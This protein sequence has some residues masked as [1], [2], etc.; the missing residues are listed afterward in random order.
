[1]SNF[2]V[3]Y[4]VGN[5]FGRD[6]QMWPTLLRSEFLTLLGGDTVDTRRIADVERPLGIPLDAMQMLSWRV[7]EWQIPATSFAAAG[8]RFDL[9]GSGCGFDNAVHFTLAGN[10]PAFNFQIHRKIPT[11][12][13]FRNVTDEKDILGPWDDQPLRNDFFYPGGLN[14]P[15][16]IWKTLRNAGSTA[17]ADRDLI[18]IAETLIEPYNHSLF[19]PRTSVDFD[20]NFTLFEFLRNY[21]IYD[22][23][24]KKFYPPINLNYT[25]NFPAAGTSMWEA[26][27]IPSV[28]HETPEFPDVSYGTLTIN[29]GMSGVSS[30]TVPLGRLGDRQLTAAE[31]LDGCTIPGS[32][33]RGPAGGMDIVM[34]AI[35]FWPFQNSLGQAVYDATDGHQIANPFV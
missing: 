31:I 13:G 5:T 24:E 29:F 34:N 35:S 28:R 15:I 10:T 9:P 23:D 19:S 30:V 20:E 12:P 25:D 3:P 2:N 32:P 21:V 18:T 22:P 26:F 4:L 11:S 14:P 16:P 8:I 27:L 33:D 6:Y 1:M 7:K 17:E